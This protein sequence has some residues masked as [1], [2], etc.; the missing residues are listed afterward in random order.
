MEDSDGNGNGRK[1]NINHFAPLFESGDEEDNKQSKIPKT[2]IILLS[3]DE[4][5]ININGEQNK[6]NEEDED[7]WGKKTTARID[8]PNSYDEINGDFGIAYYEDNSNNYKEEHILR[9]KLG[10]I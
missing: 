10:P 6:V 1:T 8:N 4:E 7:D 3:E 5:E 2:P 9:A